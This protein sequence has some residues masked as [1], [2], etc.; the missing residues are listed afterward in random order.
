M[1]GSKTEQATPK[2]KKD[3]AEK[4]QSFKSK[5]LVISCLI[6]MGVQ[7]LVSFSDVEE[8]MSL[9]RRII[10]NG[11]TSDLSEYAK[12]VFR[13][14]LKLFIPF[15]LL[16][17]FSSALPTLL[18][19]GF[20]IAKKALKLN[21]DAVNPVNGFKKLFSL[22]TIKDVIK[23]LLFL[24]SFAF[25]VIMFWD[26]NKVIV[27]SQVNA[28][29]RQILPLWGELFSSLI[30]LCL[31]SI[32][33]VLVLDALAEFFLHMKDLKMEKQEV[34]REHKEQDGD[35][36]I[37]SKRK[38]LHME[39]L[40]EQVKSDIKNSKVIIANPTHIAVGVYLNLDV[41]GIPF[42]SVLE[43][44]QRAL[45][46]RAY[47]EKVGVPVVE[48]IKLA[49]RIFKTHKRY[50]FVSLE[51]LDEIIEILMWLQQVE[52]AWMSENP[53]PGPRESE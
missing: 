37:K 28:D 43:T 48:N 11:F 39:L 9:W 17:I 26:K 10:E 12:A 27:F 24:V 53:D 41:V 23:T 3:A 7:Y 49:R 13:T 51:D 6:L 25:A 15:L 30:Y 29:Y 20:I 42:I 21:F 34:K 1:S 52:T 47:A 45:A 46:V 50:S 16:C 18:Q 36:E 8:L 40:S 33:I 5:D 38:E 22:R 31:C 2:K 19:T 32:L 35:P 14:S 4:G 44:N